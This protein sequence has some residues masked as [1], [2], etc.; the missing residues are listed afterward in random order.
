MLLPAESMH[1]PCLSMGTQVLCCSITAGGGYEELQE[2][3]TRLLG[4]VA[5]GMACHPH[6]CQVGILVH[7]LLVICKILKVTESEKTSTFAVFLNTG[8]VSNPYS[9]KLRFLQLSCFL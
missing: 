1:S 5:A 7:D 2:K 3:K 8:L 4:Q 6:E 9:L